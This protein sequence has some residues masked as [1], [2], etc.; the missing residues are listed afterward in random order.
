MPCEGPADRQKSVFH[1]VLLPDRLI[2]FCVVWTRIRPILE[3]EV[4]ERKAQRIKRQIAALK[5][6]RRQILAAR[7]KEFQR[8]LRPSQWK[9]L[10]STLEI[11]AF[12]PFARHIEAD[13]GVKVDGKMFDDAFVALPELLAVA[14][15]QYKATLRALMD[16]T[17][18][19]EGEI[20]ADPLDL[21]TAAFKCSKCRNSLFSPCV[22]GWNEIAT[23]HC[24]PEDPVE[25][26][27]SP[28][29]A[30][31][32][33]KLAQ[34]TGLDAATATPA[35]FDEKNFRYGCDACPRIKDHGQSYRLG[36]SWQNLVNFLFFL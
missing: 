19:E 28:E 24:P 14:A 2:L 9:Y 22:F 6:N 33:R 11:S 3:P 25:F 16:G 32:V 15:E 21:A 17:T 5:T 36:Y 18:R 30:N 7:Y 31:V 13:V 29:I 35:D 12:E 4:Q 27:Y 1:N 10:P 8:T 34:L 23:H 26:R 20:A